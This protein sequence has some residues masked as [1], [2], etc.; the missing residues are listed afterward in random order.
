MLD[1]QTVGILF[2]CVRVLFFGGQTF[3]RGYE[4]ISVWW[5]VFQQILG[6]VTA[7]YWV[8]LCPSPSGVQKHV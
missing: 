5:C 3:L 7:H 2:S 1:L 4:S 6:L 8:E